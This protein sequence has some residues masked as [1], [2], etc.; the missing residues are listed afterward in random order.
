MLSALKMCLNKRGQA[1]FGEYVIVIFVVVTVTFAMTV[2]VRRTL[3]GRIYDARQTMLRTVRAEYNG[4]LYRE[5]E[6]Y[7]GFRNATIDQYSNPTT[8]LLEGGTSGIFREDTNDRTEVKSYT[9]QKPP[10]DAD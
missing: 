7:Y 9:E 3:Q 6:P 2:Y 10:K 5:Y 8:R 1:V 4:V